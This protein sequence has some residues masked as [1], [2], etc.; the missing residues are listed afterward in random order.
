MSFAPAIG[1]LA[2]QFLAAFAL[3]AAL[4]PV[5]RMLSRKY[6]KVAHPREDR[7][8]RRPVAL[9]G[10][11]AMGVTLLACA[12]VFGLYRDVPVLLICATLSFVVGLVDDFITLK[13][14][15]KLIAQ[16]AIASAV[17]FFGYRLFWVRSITADSLLTLVWV[18]G[19]TNAF[20]LLDN[21]DGL[22]AGIAMIVTATLLFDLAPRGGVGAGLALPEAQYLAMLGGATAGFLIYNLYPASI[23]MGDSGAF[24]IGFSLAALTLTHA[25]EAAPRSNLLSVVAVPVLVLLIPIFDSTFVSVVR[26]LSG[27]SVAVGGRDHSSHRLVAIGLSERKAVMVLWLLAAVGGAIAIAMSYISQSW[28]VLIGLVF[29]LTMVIIAIYLARIRV[30]EGDDARMLREGTVTPLVVEFMYK[31]RVAEVLLDFSLVV[32][33]YY[34]AYKFRFE[35]EDFL[36]NFGSFRNSL[37]VILTTQMIAFFGVGVYRGVWRYFGLSDTI[38]VAKG[39]FIG[40][41][42]AQLVVLYSPWFIGYSR[43]V[44]AIY[45][46]LLVGFVT[47]SRASFLLIGEFVNR[48]RHASRRAI[49][50]GAGDAGALA[51][52]ELL[53]S[54]DEMIRIL[55]FV[56]DDPQ[57]RGTRVRGY[58]VIGDVQTLMQSIAEGQVDAIIVSSRSIPEETVRAVAASGA[59]HGVSVTRL[60]VGLE[61]VMFSAHDDAEGVQAAQGGGKSLPFP[62]PGE[63]RPRQK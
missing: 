5:C 9:F 4:V 47:L 20:N 11:V 21:M 62:A 45:A 37:P 12:L 48:Q 49:I 46:V 51:V 7:W 31:R 34:A 35:G 30:Y 42:I 44:F 58:R 28:S 59:R 54:R 16:I 17:L 25:H 60:R 36:K 38:V 57:K 1:R 29:V 10:G 2:G 61:E 52:R 8:H 40:T 27:R 26:V 23:F 19:V 43:T 18:V 39:V 14:S 32:I 3:S 6:G 50:Y 53:R 56:D 15:T 33:A 13:P 24:L 63:R 22:C 55:G 41:A